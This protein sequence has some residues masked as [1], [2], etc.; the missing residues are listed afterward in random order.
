MVVKTV[1][2]IA[3][4]DPTKFMKLLKNNPS[5]ITMITCTDDIINH[6]CSDIP[7]L[8]KILKYTKNKQLLETSISVYPQLIKYVSFQYEELCY[9]SV[10]TEPINIK[11]INNIT[12][13]LGILAVTFDGLLLKHIKMQTEAICDA[14]IIQN[15]AAFKYIINPTK[16]QKDLCTNIIIVKYDNIEEHI[17][18]Y[19]N[20]ETFINQIYDD[21]IYLSDHSQVPDAFANIDVEKNVHY[22]IKK[23]EI[24]YVYKLT[25]YKESNGWIF[26]TDN[27]LYKYTLDKTFY[28]F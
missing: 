27:K 14:A 8:K 6:L 5:L 20:I 21:V 25:I 15:K 13:K 9:I 7:L 18:T 23:N 24:Y 12:D 2:Q 19:D 10:K 11:Y 16:K 28:F 17:R 3:S 26:K 4:D 1:A 22:A